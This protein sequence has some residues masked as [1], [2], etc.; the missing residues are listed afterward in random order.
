MTPSPPGRKRYAAEAPPDRWQL[1]GELLQ[2]RRQEL[3]FKF[4]PAFAKERLPPTP[5]GNPNVRLA[6]DVEKAYRRSYP[7]GT[8]RLLAR[9]YGVTYESVEAVLRGD[10]GE[11]APE[12]AA[13]RPPD[14]T[15]PPYL[16]ARGEADRP[17]FD[18]I[19]ER[20]VALALRGITAPS[21]AQMFGEGTDDAQLWD[22]IGGRLE[23]RDRVWFI[24]DLRRRAA[25]RGGNSGSSA[26]GLSRSY[27]AAG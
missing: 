4:R 22:G 18:E 27:V 13:A 23:I 10:S 8:L 2:A 19:N 21:G 14:D 20:R 3:G 17:W 15:P 11:L 12:A 9:A 6:A 24:A 5:D 16:R 26:A 1:L 25:G 7:P